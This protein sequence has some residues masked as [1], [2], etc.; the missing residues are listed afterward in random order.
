MVLYFALYG[1]AR[2]HHIPDKNHALMYEAV[3]CSKGHEPRVC[4]LKEERWLCSDKEC[5]GKTY[6]LEPLLTAAHRSTANQVFK[7]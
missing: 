1:N 7:V 6:F 2:Q 5:R 3:T 4:T